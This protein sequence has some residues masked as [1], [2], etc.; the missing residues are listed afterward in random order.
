METDSDT[1]EICWQIFDR[2]C[3]QSGTV[4]VRDDRSWIGQ[5]LMQFY[6]SVT[7]QA[8]IKLAALGLQISTQ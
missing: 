6:L 1:L 2:E 4:A 7:M 3:V 8:S 5:S